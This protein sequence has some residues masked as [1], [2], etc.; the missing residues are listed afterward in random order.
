M[1]FKPASPRELNNVSEVKGLPAGHWAVG[2]VELCEG[3]QSF[4]P[5]GL[6]ISKWAAGP[7]VVLSSLAH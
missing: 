6:W 1:Q 3:H 4:F 5:V 7:E 2:R